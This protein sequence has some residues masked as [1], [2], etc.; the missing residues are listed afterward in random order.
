MHNASDPEVLDMQLSHPRGSVQSSLGI[1]L[2][3]RPESIQYAFSV[4]H[5]LP[6][7]GI[8]MHVIVDIVLDI[9]N[10]PVNRCIGQF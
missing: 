9:R 8:S 5:T 2:L 6:K 10:T 1:W 3:E 7:E 4:I